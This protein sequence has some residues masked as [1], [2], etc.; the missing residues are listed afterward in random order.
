MINFQYYLS[1][2]QNAV[3]SQAVV[4]YNDLLFASHSEVAIATVCRTPLKG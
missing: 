2:N 1:V 4:N 3:I